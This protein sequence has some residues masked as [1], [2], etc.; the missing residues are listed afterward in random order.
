VRRV[1]EQHRGGAHFFSCRSPALPAGGTGNG[2]A[3]SNGHVADVMLVRT[4]G[5]QT[6]LSAE[7]AGADAVVLVATTDDAAA[8]ARA[9]GDACTAH[10]IMTAG[11]V[12]AGRD[13]SV[14]V[15]TLRPYA[16]VLMVTHDEQDLAELLTA[17][18]A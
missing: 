18:R 5:S 6:R 10:G 15:S 13:A 8:A 17:L 11:L 2:N 1:A 9:I 12:F 4:D 14:T 16:R 3:R 7:L